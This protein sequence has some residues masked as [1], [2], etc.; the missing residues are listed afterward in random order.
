MAAAGRRGTSDRPGDRRRRARQGLGT[1]GPRG[2]LLRGNRVGL[3]ERLDPVDDAAQQRDLRDQRQ[4][5]LIALARSVREHVPKCLPRIRDGD[6]W[7]CA[8]HEDC[9]RES[10]TDTEPSR[11]RPTP[12]VGST[13]AMSTGNAFADQAEGPCRRHGRNGPPVRS[14]AVGARRAQAVEHGH[15]RR[16]RPR[17]PGTVPPRRGAGSRRT[18][19]AGSRPLFT[20][21]AGDTPE[22]EKRG[23]R[24]ERGSR[25]GR[26]H[27]KDNGRGR[28]TSATSRRGRTGRQCARA[29]RTGRPSA[30]PGHGWSGA[31][32]PPPRPA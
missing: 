18:P 24:H 27:G 32:G 14:A 13:A 20:T 22:Q 8:H 29:R 3:A 11:R 5:Q 30:P 15:G 17:G 19:R 25:P 1:R 28:R 7:L 4:A 31:H 16:T 12:A 9:L 26:G 10:L 2:D 6:R 21:T 23:V